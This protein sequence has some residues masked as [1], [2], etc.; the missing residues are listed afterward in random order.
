MSDTNTTNQNIVA[1]LDT[2]GR[3]IF[4][5]KDENLSTD[6]VLAVKNPVVLNVSQQDQQ[7]RMSVQVIPLFI[8]EFLAEK[9]ADV[10]FFYK[11]SNITLTDIT[12]FDFRL[13]AQ[14]AQLFNPSN[15]FVPPNA[16]GVTPATPA[17][18]NSVI[19]LFD[20]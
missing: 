11:T 19:N 1:F 9:T 10:T 5:T 20:E 17:E 7:G 15:I 6:S 3:T 14:Y 2:I 4:G 16:G 18:G 12:A 8:R 13:Q